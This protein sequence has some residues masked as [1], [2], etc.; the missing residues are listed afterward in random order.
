VAGDPPVAGLGQQGLIQRESTSVPPPDGAGR[1]V[2]PE[3]ECRPI[4]NRVVRTL[5]TLRCRRSMRT[6]LTHPLHVPEVVMCGR[7]ITQEIVVAGWRELTC[8]AAAHL[9]QAPAR[10]TKGG[11]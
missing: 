8:F 9:F 5:L 3:H 7:E 6:C 2:G 10:S 4:L 1:Q 11:A